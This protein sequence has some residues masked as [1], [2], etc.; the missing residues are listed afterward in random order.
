MSTTAS[1]LH[2]VPARAAPAA[3][4]FASFLMGGFEAA[5][6][7]RPDGVRLDMIAGAGHD[8][9]A[10]V[11]YALLAQHGIGT[12]RDAVR[13]H[14]VEQ[15]PGAYDWSSWIPQL[16]AARDAGVQVAWDLCHWGLP[17]WADVTSSEFISRFAAFCR[18]AAGIARAHAGA[19]PPLFCPINEISYWS[20]AAEH[21][22][23][24]PAMPTEGAR[25]KRILVRAAIAAM[26][27]VREAWP[28]A[29]FLHAEPLVHVST[30]VPWEEGAWA[31]ARAYREAQFETMDLLAGRAEPELGGGPGYVDIVGAN[32][33]FDNQWWQEGGTIPFGSR[34]YMPLCDLLAELAARYGRPVVLSETCAEAVGGAAWLRYVFA[35]AREA[36]ARGVDLLGLCLY[37][38]ADYP[39][40]ADGR[41]CRCGLIEI[42]LD[43]RQRRIAPEIARVLAEAATMFAPLPR[44]AA[45]HL[46]RVG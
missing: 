42:D 41:H 36:M 5:T 15:V 44:V 24:A 31:R 34:E 30:R 4:P 20:W 9:M 26:D 23:M 46:A 25:L 33:Y 37:P 39:G 29:R 22:A 18:A 38:V 35:E 1:A 14:V 13:W 7:V 19:R 6:H 3:S 11:D 40:W 32:F 27:A 8:R 16:Q 17:D 10:A 12:A 21:G 45:P 43:W 28:E 2:A